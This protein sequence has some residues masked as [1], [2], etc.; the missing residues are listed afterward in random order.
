M[1]LEGLMGKG[2][3][4]TRAGLVRR[5]GLCEVKASLHH[6][7]VY[8]STHLYPVT[9]VCREVRIE[10]EDTAR[11]TPESMRVRGEEDFSSFTCS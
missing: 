3:R 8:F 10:A 9:S 11:K 6:I 2:E 1:M 7:C 5:G 4:G